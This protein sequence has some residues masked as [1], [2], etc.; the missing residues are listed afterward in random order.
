MRPTNP[1]AGAVAPPSGTDLAGAVPDVLLA[2]IADH[3]PDRT[4]ALTRFHDNSFLSI[5]GL[6]RSLRT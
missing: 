1:A 2:E 5:F 3:A 4:T 6:P